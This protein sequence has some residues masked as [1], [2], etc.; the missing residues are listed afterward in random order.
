MTNPNSLIIPA[1]EVDE[2]NTCQITATLKAPGGAV[3]PVANI[4]TATLNLWNNTTGI[5]IGT[6][7][8]NVAA[9]FSSL[10]VFTYVLTTTD[11]AIISTDTSIQFEDHTAAL[12][13]VFTAGT[14]THT[15]IK[16]IRVRVRN[17]AYLT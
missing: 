8:R 1:Q 3:V 6:A 9:Y 13:V 15:L 17:L 14:E 4:T 2:K 5:V 16:N 10:G 11:N 7:D 12:K